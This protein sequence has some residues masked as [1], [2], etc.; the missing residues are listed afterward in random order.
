MPALNGF[1]GSTAQIGAE[2]L[3]EVTGPCPSGAFERAQVRCTCTMD[4]PVLLALL[5][6]A[7]FCACAEFV[8]C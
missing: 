6:R 5:G 8:D 1:V 7:G 3:I 4:L 2:R